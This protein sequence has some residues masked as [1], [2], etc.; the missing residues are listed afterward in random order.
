[1]VSGNVAREPVFSPKSGRI[2]ERSTVVSYI[3]KFHKDPVTNDE[4]AEED[5]LPVAAATA[6]AILPTTTSIPSLL[7]A[8]QTEWDSVALEIFLLK[9]QVQKAREELSVALYHHDAAVRV[10]SK[11]LQERDEYKKALQELSASV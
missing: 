10:A 4:L 11:A 2:F 8:M 6:P 3:Q 1:T 5:L 7:S 9:K